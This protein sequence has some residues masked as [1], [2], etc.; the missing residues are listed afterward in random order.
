MRSI[1]SVLKLVVIAFCY[2]TESIKLL[3][4]A[5][6]LSV[7]AGSSTCV[8]PGVRVRRTRRLAVRLAVPDLPQTD[9]F[10]HPMPRCHA[11]PHLP[12]VRPPRHLLH[13]RK[14]CDEVRFS[15]VT[16]TY[17]KFNSS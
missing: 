7:E 5:V 10:A 3:S 15:T 13:L 8:G 14:P 4:P 17:L 12:R 2:P 6:A 9:R 16:V 1:Y 11:T